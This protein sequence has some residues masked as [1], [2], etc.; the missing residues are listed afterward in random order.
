MPKPIERIFHTIEQL[1]SGFHSI[2]A[3]TL[4]DSLELE[5]SETL[6]WISQTY[7][8][9]MMQNLYLL[10]L[11]NKEEVTFITEHGD[12]GHL[13]GVS[14]PW[15]SIRQAKDSIEAKEEWTDM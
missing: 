3:L 12:S 13:I 1:I 7:S 10:K 14:G 2:D 6:E 15:D 8:A 5:D 11:Q 4:G 9:G